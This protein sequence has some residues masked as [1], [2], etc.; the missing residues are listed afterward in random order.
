MK[1]KKLYLLIFAVIVLVIIF[2]YVMIRLIVAN[3]ECSDN[4]F[5]YGA[6]FMS[7]K[8]TSILC[9]CNSF[10]GNVRFWYDEKGMYINNPLIQIKDD[11]NY[12]DIK[13]TKP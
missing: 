8:E 3:K 6:K 4:P 13:F 10:D 2:A 9:S 11:F 1:I 5:I 12:S 7:E